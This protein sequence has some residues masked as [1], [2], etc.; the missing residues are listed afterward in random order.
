[1]DDKKSVKD[2]VKAFDTNQTNQTNQKKDLQKVNTAAAPKEKNPLFPTLK[3]LPKDV[4]NK[5][6][7]E[8]HQKNEDTNNYEKKKYQ[9]EYKTKED[10][11]NKQKEKKKK[12]KKKKKK[13]EEKKQNKKENAKNKKED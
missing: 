4:N 1:M 10:K 5:Y 11:N 3:K 7:E 9:T 12:K 13:E 6:T 2:L 8:I